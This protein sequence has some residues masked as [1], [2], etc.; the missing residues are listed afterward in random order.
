M[1]AQHDLDRQLNAFLVDG[2]TSL[3]D[4]SFDAVRDR[5][6]QTR[7]RVVLGPWRVPTVSKLVPIGLGAAAVIAVLFLGS[8]FIGSPSS[9]VG[10][11]ASQPT[12]SA[13]PSTTPIG[14]KVEYRSDGN[15]ATTEVEAVADG[16]SVSGTAVSTSPSGTHT[17]Q[18]ECAVRDGD[19][20]AFGGTVEQT[21]V[22]G[23]RAGYWS[24]VMVRDGSRQ[25]VAIWLS[26]D[27]V[28]GIDCAGWL[29][30]VDMADVGLEN[31]VAVDS[32]ALVPPPDLAP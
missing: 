4:A 5:T 11:P 7:Q 29:G 13:T 28:E 19:T 14:G 21:T 15:P 3:P 17:V 25:H 2:P 16:S 22:P 18:L 10:G 8:Q 12:A 9:S 6:E 24:A 30:A 27:K 1:S 20:W 31:F 23:E 32:G 26:D